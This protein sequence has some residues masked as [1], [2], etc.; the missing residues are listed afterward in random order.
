MVER[1]M[2]GDLRP[3][4]PKVGPTGPSPRWPT[5]QKVAEEVGE[6]G[7]EWSTG[8]RRGERVSYCD[9]L[10]T[11]RAKIRADSACVRQRL[12]KTGQGDGEDRRP[13]PFL[14]WHGSYRS[15]TG[16]A[17]RGRSQR[18]CG[19]RV[20][21]DG[22]GVRCTSWDHRDGR[23]GTQRDVREPAPSLHGSGEVPEMQDR[24]P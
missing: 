3:G 16:P 24:C 1:A 22:R 6:P 7:S 18:A 5:D 12:R 9:R 11:T 4:L 2:Q 8:L 15:P 14:P 23:R 20:G 19:A 21:V 10:A 17:P 13:P